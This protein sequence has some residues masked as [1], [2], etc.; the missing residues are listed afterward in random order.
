ML[1]VSVDPD[2]DRCTS[3]DSHLDLDTQDTLSEQNVPDSLVHKVL[4]GLTGVDHEPVGELH[5]LGTGGTEFTGNDDFATLGAGLHDESEDTVA[6]TEV[7]T[8]LG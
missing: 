1:I 3:V 8:S 6:C 7:S 2:R 5:R 4:C